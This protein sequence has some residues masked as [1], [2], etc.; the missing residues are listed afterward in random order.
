MTFPSHDEYP[1]C[2]SAQYDHERVQYRY[3]QHTG[4]QY[5]PNPAWWGAVCAGTDWSL[6]P[7]SN[8][9]FSKERSTRTTLGCILSKAITMLLMLL[10]C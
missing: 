8:R 6:S 1:M 9:D 10:I 2:P 7:L 4:A 5:E 3:S